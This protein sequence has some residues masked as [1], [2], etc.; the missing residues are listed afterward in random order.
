M[1]FV[2]CGY[3]G[4]PGT[5]ATIAPPSGGVKR[6]TGCPQ[7]EADARAEA[8]AAQAARAAQQARE[9]LQ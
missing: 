1:G 7:C 3:C 8:E 6:C 2:T 9:Q 4:H 5:H